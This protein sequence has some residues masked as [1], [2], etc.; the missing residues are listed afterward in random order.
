MEHR[1]SLRAEWTGN[2]GTG[3]SG[4]KDFDRDVVIQA[5]GPG[6]LAGSAAAAFHGDTNRWNPEQLVLAA[7]AECHILSY[8]YVATQAG[9]VVTQM[10]CGADLTL[11]HTAD[12]GQISSATLYPEVWLQDEAQREKAEELHEDA[13]QQCFIA[14][15]VNFP[16]ALEPQ[17]QRQMSHLPEFSSRLGA[18]I[19][20][21]RPRVA[22]GPSQVTGLADRPTSTSTS[23]KPSTPE[24]SSDGE[25][26]P[27]SQ[28]KPP[29][30]QKSFYEQVGGHDTFVKLC[31]VFYQ[32]VAGDPVLREMYPEEDL[33]PAEVR[34]RMFLEQYWGG[35]TTYS[36]QR[37]H[38]RLRMRH[39][40]YQVT[41]EARDRWLTHMRTAVDSLELAPLHENTLWDYLERAAHAMV[42]A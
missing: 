1:F 11:K 38:P 33:G 24:Q 40:P 19:A 34:L 26:K 18:P 23:E 6:E 39:N 4:P 22:K 28:E 7:L 12:G 17:Q 15:S 31:R 2:R 42:N 21:L 36:Q 9:V 13:H 30:V 35:P 37:G 32:E 10:S 25:Q 5:E 3:T 27:A 20:V 14:R 41:F 8:L 16:V 29:T